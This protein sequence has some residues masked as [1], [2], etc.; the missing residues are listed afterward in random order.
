MVN[1]PERA[2]S[3][4]RISQRRGTARR[5]A[6]K[7]YLTRRDDLVRGA[8]EL[9]AEQG[10]EV[11]TFADIATRVGM[12]RATLYYYVSSKDELLRDVIGEAVT[13]N[14]A[15]C[16][17]VLRR[18]IPTRDKLALIVDQLVHSYEQNYP[19]VSVYTQ[20]DMQRTQ[21]TTE[22]G[23][24]VA[25]Q[26]RRIEA[27]VARII[28][29]GKRDGTLRGDVPTDLISKGLFG[30]VNWTHRWYRPGGA[31]TAADIGAAFSRLL[32]DGI[33]TSSPRSSLT[34]SSGPTPT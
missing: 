28:D 21:P 10:Y 27:I 31:H 11:T 18:R 2:S 19:Y 6:R 16:E 4:S 29:D 15:A 5:G 34:T 25:R 9:F 13:E 23:T 24:E 26:S 30:M 17:R 33:F 14:L 8:A 20:H 3:E 12:D 32:F 7:A 1:E 22:W